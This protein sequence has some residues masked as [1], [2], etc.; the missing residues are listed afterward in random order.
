MKTELTGT[1]GGGRD[2]T[3]DKAPE[4]RRE[5]FLSYCRS[6]RNLSAKT[7]E[8]YRRDIA[9]FQAYCID[10]GLEEREIGD[11]EA[12][13]FV[14]ELSRKKM[15]N[16][17]INRAVSALRKYYSFLVKYEGFETDPFA[18]MKGMK[19]QN[20][21]PDFL[22]ER[23]IADLLK[24]PGGDFWG[25]RDS[26]IFELLYSTGCRISELTAINISDISLK[27]RS[28]RVT[29]KGGKERIVFLGRGAMEALREYLPRKNSRADKNDVDAMNALFLNYRG[30]RITQRG[31][32]GIINKYVTRLGIAKRV[33]PH[34]FRHSFAT[35][36]INRG[37]DIRAVQELLGHASL[38][39]TQIYTHLGLARLRQIYSDAHPHA[40]KTSRDKGEAIENE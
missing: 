8:A 21:L 6:V 16:S 40:K 10:L 5:K 22:F 37:A 26:C 28:I 7:V 32:F 27:E 11:R 9:A 29:G 20:T 31:I 36:L 23:E 12:R 35:H 17:S 1:A 33:G 38:S 34:T 2:G 39:T 24:L 3:E 19:K 18:E 13:G 15:A 25:L 14:S 30:K 4:K